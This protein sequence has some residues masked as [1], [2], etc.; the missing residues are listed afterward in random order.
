MRG[1]LHEDIGGKGGIKRSPR[2][3]LM[4]QLPAMLRIQSS[5]KQLDSD[6]AQLFD[7]A[8][9]ERCQLAFKIPS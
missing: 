5:A 8:G 2:S 3:P 4:Q 1:L 7:P 9:I 6:S